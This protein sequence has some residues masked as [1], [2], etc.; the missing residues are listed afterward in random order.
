[1]L[2]GKQYKRK[3]N[4]KENTLLREGREGFVIELVEMLILGNEEDHES[5]V[6]FNERLWNKSVENRNG[7]D[8]MDAIFTEKKNLGSVRV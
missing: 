2:H 5:E 3:K 8:E 6:G 1:M 4:Q 7:D